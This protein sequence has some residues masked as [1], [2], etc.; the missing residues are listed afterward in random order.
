MDHNNDN[1]RITITVSGDMLREIDRRIPDR[2]PVCRQRF[3]L[4]LL[5]AHLTMASSAPPKANEPGPNIHE[6][7]EIFERKFQ[8]LEEALHITL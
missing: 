3:I 4:D 5:E 1:H 8:K 2:R 6:Q 7:V